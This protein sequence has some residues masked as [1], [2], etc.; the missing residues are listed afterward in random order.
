MHSVRK[1]TGKLLP[2]RKYTF[3][4]TIENDTCTGEHLSTSLALAF[5]PE[6][7]I[8]WIKDGELNFEGE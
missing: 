8:K 4:S 5:H 2:T 1:S 3:D 7:A 6:K